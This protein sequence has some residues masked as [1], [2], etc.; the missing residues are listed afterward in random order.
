[1]PS[2]DIEKRDGTGAAP[3]AA[4]PTDEHARRTV[5]ESEEHVLPHNNLPLGTCTCAYTHDRR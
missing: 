3:G 2:M 1:M 4:T 5:R